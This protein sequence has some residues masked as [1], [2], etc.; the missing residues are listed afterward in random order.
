MTFYRRNDAPKKE[1]LGVKR[2]VISGERVMLGVFTLEPNTETQLS[3]HEA[4]QITY[5]L[6]GRLQFKVGDKEEVIGPGDVVVI[7]P[8]V[9]HSG[10]VLDEP[11]ICLDCFSPIREDLL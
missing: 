1:H 7:P 2:Q 3:V 11:V 10:R 8:N 5:V 4:E 6:K 9:P